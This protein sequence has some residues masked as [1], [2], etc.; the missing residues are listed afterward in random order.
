MWY[1]GSRLQNQAGLFPAAAP[2]ATGTPGGLAEHRAFSDAGANYFLSG[3]GYG[4]VNTGGNGYL[5]TLWRFTAPV[6]VRAAVNF[7]P[8]P[9]QP[10]STGA[11]VGIVVGSVVALIIII[12]ALLFIIKACKNADCSCCKR[13]A[14]STPPPSYGGGAVGSEPSAPTLTEAELVAMER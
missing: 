4:A 10:L 5:T 1:G 2:G 12:V 6:S 9:T 14:H 13:H 7:A 3:R 8:L 11:I